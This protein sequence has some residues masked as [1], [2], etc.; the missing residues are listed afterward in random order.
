MLEC[1]R[2]HR[3]PVIGGIPVILIAEVQPTHHAFSETF[4]LVARSALGALPM[5]DA[6]ESNDVHPF[7]EQEIVGTC[8]L[9]YRAVRRPLP[10][11]P[12]P[13][14]PLGGGGGRALLDV[15]CNWGRWTIAAAMAGYRAVGIDP[16]LKAVAAGRSVSQ[17]L[18]QDVG[19]VVG[20]ARHLPFRND[21]FDVTFSYSVFQHFD[22]KDV[23]EALHEV[24]RVLR[25]K[26]TALVQMANVF[27]ARSTLNRLWQ[28]VTNDQNPF[29]VRY[30]TPGELI[31]CFKET[32]GETRLSADGFF[33]LNARIE[34]LDLLPSR[35]KAVVWSSEWL[36]RLSE[37]VWWLVYVA[38]SLWVYATRRVP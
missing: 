31:R 5:T 8:G 13:R 14:F 3:Y 26:G 38:D 30:W 25:R 24:A 1:P 34:D 27:G 29:R 36:R 37:R 21:A 12:I 9:L 6:G 28:V 23:R 16:S 10:R 2:G 17:Q 32:I 20:D 15:G 35:Y 18:G 33:S 22:K 4:Q 11:Y 7:V 19:Y